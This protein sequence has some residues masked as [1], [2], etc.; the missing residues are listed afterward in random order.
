M[1]ETAPADHV[2]KEWPPDTIATESFTLDDVTFTPTDDGRFEHATRDGHYPIGD[3]LHDDNRFWFAR[4]LIDNEL[5]D[6]K[7][8]RCVHEARA[9][10]VSK[11]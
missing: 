11:R 1:T 8:M 4:K 5:S 3:V 7:P 2:L 10:L 6:W 9:Y